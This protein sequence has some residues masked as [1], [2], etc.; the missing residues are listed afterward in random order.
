MNLVVYPFI[1]L[2]IVCIWYLHHTSIFFSS[3]H[4]TDCFACQAAEGPAVDPKTFDGLAA[5]EARVNA[6][7]NDTSA[8]DN[9]QETEAYM[10]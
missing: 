4:P 10:R 1:F 3:S 9:A 7:R 8:G 6:D 5:M 2:I